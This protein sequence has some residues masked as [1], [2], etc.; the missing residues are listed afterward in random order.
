MKLFINGKEAYFSDWKN[1]TFP[2][3]HPELILEDIDRD[4]R[5]ELIVIL[6]KDH[7]TGY[8]QTE[9][10]VIDPETLEETLIDSPIAIVLKNVKTK[11]M[12][13]KAEIKIGTKKRIVELPEHLGRLN[14]I[15]FKD[16][17]QFEVS[18]NH[19][20][21]IVYAKAAQIPVADIKITYHYKDKMY[22][23]KTIELM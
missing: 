3:H 2:D 11:I 18:D 6:T 1:S 12:D 19:L 10:H 7:G 21:A 22:Q 4:G 20:I 13:G 8:L 23:A 15:H 5:K 17:I 16:V 9:A 14:E